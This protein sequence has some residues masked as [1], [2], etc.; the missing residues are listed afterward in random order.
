ME[1]IGS[2][3]MEEEIRSMDELLDI[4][5]SQKLLTI[6]MSENEDPYLA[7]LDF[8]FDESRPCF[9]FHTS[10]SGRK[11]S[12]LRKNPKVFGQVHEDRGFVKDACDHSFRLV[13][14]RGIVSFPTDPEEIE[15]GLTSI[16]SHLGSDPDPIVRGDMVKG[17]I[18]GRIDILEISGR[19]NEPSK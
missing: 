1:C 19:K 13:Q 17:T 5:R 4:I 15:K 12:I 7:T 2:R 11:V 6:A 18:V 16:L 8:G 3:T 10:A 14:F 9:Y